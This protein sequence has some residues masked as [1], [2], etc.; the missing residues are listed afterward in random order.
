MADDAKTKVIDKLLNGGVAG[1]ILIVAGWW[2]STY[3]AVPAMNDHR[4]FLREQVKIGNQHT[5]I[6]KSMEASMLY[7]DRW[8]AQQAEKE[9]G[10]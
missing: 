10:K 6:L 1:A 4:E 3:I 8:Y 9:K 5:E 7:K 2:F